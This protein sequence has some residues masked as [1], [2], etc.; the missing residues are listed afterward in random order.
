MRHITQKVV[1]NVFPKKTSKKSKRPSPPPK[2]NRRLLPYGHLQN[3]MVF[4]TYA[5]GGGEIYS[6]HQ[7]PS[8]LIDTL[9]EKLVAHMNAGVAAEKRLFDQMAKIHTDQIKLKEDL[10]RDLEAKHQGPSPTTASMG[11]QSDPDPMPQKEYREAAAQH[12]QNDI[13]NVNKRTRVDPGGPSGEYAVPIK[14][15]RARL[16]AVYQEFMGNV[17]PRQRKAGYSDG[18]SSSRPSKRSRVDNDMEE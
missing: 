10:L 8:R 15:M 13:P 16:D 9:N 7:V 18:A 17:G 11:T 12:T 3:P 5:P 14:R 4:G 6:G 1:V 2:N